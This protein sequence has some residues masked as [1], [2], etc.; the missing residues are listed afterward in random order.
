MVSW[1]KTEK[2]LELTTDQHQILV[3]FSLSPASVL[4]NTKHPQS[5]IGRIYC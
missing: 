2:Q 1:F 5:F 4:A 3:F